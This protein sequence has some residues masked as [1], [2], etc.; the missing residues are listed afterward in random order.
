MILQCH[1]AASFASA[2][3]DDAVSPAAIEEAPSPAN[4]GGASAW[5]SVSEWRE[6]PGLTWGDTPVQ[7]TLGKD[8]SGF[9]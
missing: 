5:R 1:R 4:P 3:S 7:V 8:P 9:E 2:R 6:E